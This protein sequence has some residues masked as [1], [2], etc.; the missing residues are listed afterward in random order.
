M[1]SS[2]EAGEYLKSMGFERLGCGCE[3]I[4]FAR[5]GSDYVIKVVYSAFEESGLHQKYSYLM[6]KKEFAKTKV[7]RH[8]HKRKD[9]HMVVIQERVKNTI[10]DYVWSTKP[11]SKYYHNKY[12]RMVDEVRDKFGVRDTHDENV[13]VGEGGRVIIFDWVVHTEYILPQYR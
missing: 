13:G 9:H 12:Q 11:K 5:P 1:D 7:F 2:M 4:A 10:W 3:A 8:P 6:G